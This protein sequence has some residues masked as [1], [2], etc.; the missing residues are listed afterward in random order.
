MGVAVRFQVYEAAKYIKNF[1]FVWWSILCTVFYGGSWGVK[2]VWD[3]YLYIQVHKWRNNILNDCQCH[4]T[5]E[6]IIM[7]CSFLIILYQFSPAAIDPVCQQVWWAGGWGWA[8]PWGR[9]PK[10]W[11]HSQRQ[12]SKARLCSS[13][14]ISVTS[15]CWVCWQVC[16]SVLYCEQPSACVCLCDVMH[17]CGRVA[18]CG[19]GTCSV[20]SWVSKYVSTQEYWRV[21][22]TCRCA[23]LGMKCA[24]AWPFWS[25]SVWGCFHRP[26]M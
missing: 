25:A 18:V 9:P 15:W 10:P 5:R 23:C 3:K 6:A 12:H 13:I 11:T 16:V 24:G 8:P 4:Q 1:F 2:G 21:S 26:V 17:K 19:L 7:S 22:M 20:G 14:T